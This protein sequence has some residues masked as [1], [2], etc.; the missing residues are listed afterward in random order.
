MP[1]STVY[2]TPAPCG[3][4][5]NQLGTN[6]C[7]LQH[8]PSQCQPLIEIRQYTSSKFIIFFK[9]IWLVSPLHFQV[10]F[11]ISMSISTKMSA[12]ILI[13][14]YRSI[15]RIYIIATLSF[16]IYE[17]SSSLHLFSSFLLLMFVFFS[18]QSC[19]LS[20]LSLSYFIFLIY[21]D[22]VTEFQFLIVHYQNIEIQWLF[23]YFLGI[24]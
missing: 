16:L 9:L 23:L 24:W 19:T 7:D 21:C 4:G 14:I 3:A 12:E 1:F 10:N 2:C 11:G 6:K 13:E 15:G 8:P 17:H 5:P 22:T 18:V 20:N